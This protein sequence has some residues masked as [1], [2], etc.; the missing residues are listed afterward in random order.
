[1]FN[2][3]ILRHNRLRPVSNY[4]F[5]IVF[6]VFP[7]RSRFHKFQY[8][9]IFK[10]LCRPPLAGSSFIISHSVPFVKNF[11]ED[12]F[13][14]LGLSAGRCRFRD[15]LFILL[16]SRSFVKTFFEVF[17]CRP[18][19]PFCRPPAASSLLLSGASLRSSG[20]WLC[21]R[22]CRSRQLDYNTTGTA[23]CQHFFSIFFKFFCLDFSSPISSRVCQGKA[24][25]LGPRC[26]APAGKTKAAALPGRESAAV[27]I[28]KSR[29][30]A[31]GRR[32]AVTVPAAPAGGR[33]PRRRG[34]G[35]PRRGARP[36]QGAAPPGWPPAWR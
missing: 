4:L 25:N 21:N 28:K 26:P 33:R 7:T 13:E 27:W 24:Q 20:I 11:F 10:V 19:S 36:A 15:S 34:A 31:P 35:R 5:G 32:A 16:H 2:L 3:A 12:F 29:F 8:C 17:F 30:W 14:P 1:M 9:S 6:R 18:G 23:R 22:C